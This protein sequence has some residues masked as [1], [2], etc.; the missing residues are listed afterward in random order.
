MLDIKRI[1]DDPEGCA[2]A[3]ARRGSGADL[4][5]LLEADRRR[6]AAIAEG[7]RLRHEKK[8]ASGPGADRDRLRA[9]GERIAALEGEAEAAGRD[10][11]AVL[12]DLPN[13]PADDVPDGGAEANRV[14][15]TGGPAPRPSHGV[16]HWEIG[17][18]LGLVDFDRGAKV[19]GARFYVLTG[20]GARLERA[21]VNFM[22]DLHVNE[23]GYTEVFPP[24][25]VN[26]ESMTGTGQFPKFADE[27][28]TCERDGLSLIPTAEVPVT[29]LHRDEILDGA[30]LPI[31]YC[32]YT[33]C[34]RREAGAAGKET[35]G[36]T[37][38]HQFN[39]VE[40][41]RFVRPEDSPAALEELTGHAEA[42][43][44]RLGL[45][46]RRVLL[47]AGDT[48]FASAKTYDLEVW[49]PGQDRWVEVSSCSNFTD[50]QARRLKCRFRRKEA[51]G[52]PLELVHTLNGSGL[53]VGR[54]WAAILENGLREDGSVEVPEVLR[55]YLGGIDSIR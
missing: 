16:P 50:Y 53:A 3:L 48:G 31:A 4:E 18:R 10:V 8:K 1:R 22:L 28:Y 24:F 26:G 14:V 43:L 51:P 45:A 49:M 46:Y 19:A 27:Y 20:L 37:R 21:L 6:R 52:A 7:E 23:H 38:V 40:L 17:T 36:V 29:N 39:K 35:R 42:V 44:E 25:L 33:A 13:L 41:V 54:T 9:M 2:R 5:R 11:E 15:R 12:L 55:P 32:A 47:A 30:R 34:F